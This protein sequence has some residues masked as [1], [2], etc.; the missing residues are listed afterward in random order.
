M[1]RKVPKWV[2]MLTQ[3]AREYREARCTLGSE[4]TEEMARVRILDGFEAMWPHYAARE[5]SMAM[6]METVPTTDTEEDEGPSDD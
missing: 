2:S 3:L 6:G 5:L 1:A 4:I